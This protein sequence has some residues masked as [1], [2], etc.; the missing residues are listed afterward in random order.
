MAAL[1]RSIQIPTRDVSGYFFD[2]TQDHSLGGAAAS[3][4]WVEVYIPSVGWIGL[5][6]TN[7]KIVD[8]TYIKLAVGRD[9]HAVAPVIGGDFGSDRS[10]LA[11][12]LQVERIDAHLDTDESA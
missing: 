7:N 8:K 1:C 6:P 2:A 12:S 9:Y 10:G 3:H 5:D 11:V 4:A